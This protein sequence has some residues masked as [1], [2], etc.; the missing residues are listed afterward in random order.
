MSTFLAVD[1]SRL[2]IPATGRGA[3][4]R[5]GIGFDYRYR[6]NPTGSPRIGTVAEQSLAAWAVAAGAGAIQ[7]RLMQLGF[8]D[9]PVA[10]T[11]L[12]VFGPR[13]DAAVR[14]FQRANRDPDGGA[15]LVTDGAVYRQDARA[16]WTPLIDKA[17]QANGIPGHLLRGQLSAESALDPGAI[18]Y[19]IYYGPDQAY[20]GIDRGLAQ[21]NSKA[22]ADVT[23]FQAF[24]AP[25]A[26]SYTGRALAAVYAQ[27]RDAN[28]KQA[29][30]VLWDAAVCSH[31]SPLWG[32]QWAAA[33]AP[34]TDQAALYVSNVKA[35]I[36]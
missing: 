2:P 20:G 6:L 29:T 32:R 22:R 14:A 12:G 34:P 26:I 17:E 7:R 30:A 19:Y 10:D 1:P 8:F 28:P 27:L 5:D 3:W 24:D 15:P 16:L 9:A 21:V 36:Y 13:T 23:W 33:G 11:E 35:A 18:G 31:N 25:W 4:T